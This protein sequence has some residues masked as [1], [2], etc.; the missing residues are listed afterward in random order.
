VVSTPRRRCSPGSG[1]ETGQRGGSWPAAPAAGSTGSAG[2]VGDA[3]EGSVVDGEPAPTGVVVGTPGSTR[4]VT[5]AGP[6]EGR[7]DGGADGGGAVSGSSNPSR[8][9]SRAN[10]P[11]STAKRTTTATTTA[12]RSVPRG[13]G[14]DSP[15]TSRSGGCTARTVPDEPGDAVNRAAVT[16]YG[17]GG[18]APRRRSGTPHKPE[19]PP[20]DKEHPCKRTL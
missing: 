18:M 16:P 15:G 10:P 20:G 14:R 3:P 11:M 7:V 13:R 8:E 17:L 2:S 1:S 9:P 6:D 5:L 4:P 12:T 19:P